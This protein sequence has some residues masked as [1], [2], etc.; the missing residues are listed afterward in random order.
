V[1]KMSS[2][3]FAF[4]TSNASARLPMVLFLSINKT[5]ILLLAD[6][7]ANGRSQLM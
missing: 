3:T 7:R 2:D 4:N 1:N 6:L 5:S